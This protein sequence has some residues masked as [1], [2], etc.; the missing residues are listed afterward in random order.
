M[1][2]YIG[3]GQPL[4]IGSSAQALSATPDTYDA[5]QNNIS[6]VTGGK[7]ADIT[8]EISGGSLGGLLSVRSQ[9]LQPAENTLGQFSVG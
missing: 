7:P 4:V 9:V 3:S 1:N 8:A 6:I 2:V 5:A